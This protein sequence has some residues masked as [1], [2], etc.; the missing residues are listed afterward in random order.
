MTTIYTVSTH[1]YKYGVFAL[2]NS[3]RQL[4][5]DNP[6]VVGTDVHLPEL[7][8]IDN[9][10]QFIFDVDWNGTNLKA[11]TILNNPSDSFI[12]FDAD[13]I[14]TDKNFITE[15]EK[16]L[17]KNKLVVPIEGVNSENELR[18]NYWQSIYP[19]KTDKITHGWYYNA[20]FFAGVM[21]Q[22]KY[23]L[24]DWIALNKQ[25]LNLK[26]FLFF[27]NKLPMAD[28]DTLNAILQTLPIESMVAIQMPD[29]Y[30]VAAPQHPF[31]P[32]GNFRPR[33]FL[34]CT[35]KIKPWDITTIPSRPPNTYDDL[36]YSYLFRNNTPVK[37]SF[38]LTYFQKKWFER[39]LISRIT[40]KLKSILG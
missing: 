26:E 18:R 7:D 15:V 6:I 19:S 27:N 1:N 36:W 31:H 30:S 21:A 10:T 22:H 14:L 32:I 25:Y 16:A 2:I 33:A 29:W 9:I 28:Q 4:K 38:E 37:S 35:G 8:G 13:I 3:L 23:I 40:I 39:S 12:Y 20:G 5:I 24:N 17:N 11:Y 34:H